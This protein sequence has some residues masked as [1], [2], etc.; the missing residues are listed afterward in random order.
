MNVKIGILIINNSE[1]NSIIT[2]NIVNKSVG[3]NRINISN[4]LNNKC[5]NIYVTWYQVYNFPLGGRG[6][7]IIDLYYKKEWDILFNNQIISGDY[8]KTSFLMRS[9]TLFTEITPKA[10]T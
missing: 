10:S 8:S 6:T 4:F 9:M 7:D 2:N 3:E 1:N 5:I